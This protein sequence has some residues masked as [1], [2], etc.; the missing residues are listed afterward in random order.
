MNTTGFLMLAAG[1]IVGYYLARMIFDRA[2][3]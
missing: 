1:G 2:G 3:T